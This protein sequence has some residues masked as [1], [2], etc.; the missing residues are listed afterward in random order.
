MSSAIDKSN[1]VETR[2]FLIANVERILENVSSRREAKKI[3]T[4]DLFGDIPKHNE[5]KINWKTDYNDLSKF[6][7]LMMEKENSSPILD[8]IALKPK[9]RLM[10]FPRS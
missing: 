6:N 10:L 8:A 4:D 1:I 3:D 5:T 2:S 9:H 7:I